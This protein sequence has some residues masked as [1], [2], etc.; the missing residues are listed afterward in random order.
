MLEPRTR[1]EWNITVLKGLFVLSVL[2]AIT[3]GLVVAQNAGWI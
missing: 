2:Y 1:Q 3:H